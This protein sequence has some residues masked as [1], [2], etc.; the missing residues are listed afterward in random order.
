MIV[1]CTSW[2]QTSLLKWE[3]VMGRIVQRAELESQSKSRLRELLADVGKDGMLVCI[4][5]SRFVCMI[6]YI[7][8][9]CIAEKTL[10]AV[11]VLPF[12]CPDVRTSASSEKVLYFTKVCTTCTCNFIVELHL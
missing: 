8:I 12:L 11:A 1:G 3:E 2:S 5:W 10:V 6:I 4:K 9:Y 7:H